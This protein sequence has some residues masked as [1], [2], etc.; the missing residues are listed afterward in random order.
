V[1][2][3]FL[4][5]QPQAP[6]PTSLQLKHIIH[7]EI[8]LLLSVPMNTRICSLHFS[9]LPHARRC[10]F[11]LHAIACSTSLAQSRIYSMLGSPCSEHESW[12]S[13]SR[14]FQHGSK[15]DPGLPPY[16]VWSRKIVF[17]LFTCNNCVPNFLNRHNIVCNITSF[18]MLD[19]AMSISLSDIG[20]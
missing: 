20:C 12:L 4:K 14:F 17:T 2:K 15:D 9:S 19:W 10:N 16:L 1:N 6:S 5:V 13:T 8:H 3:H 11:P 7:I 18:K